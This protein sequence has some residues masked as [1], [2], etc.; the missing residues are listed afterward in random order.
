MAPSAQAGGGS[1]QAPGAGIR[2]GI[3]AVLLGPPGAGKG[4][5]VR[6]RPAELGRGA[7]SSGPAPR[8]CAWLPR[9]GTGRA[10][11]CRGPRRVSWSRAFRPVPLPKVGTRSG[12]RDSGSG[13]ARPGGSKS[14]RPRPLL[15]RIRPGR[16]AA[17]PPLK[18]PRWALTFR[19]SFPAGSEAGRDVLCLPPGHGGHAA[20][21]GGLGLRAGQATQRDDGFG[22]AGG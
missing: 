22:E 16:C 21:H 10:G 9:G 1:G 14:E 20:G 8:A 12:Q 6:G 18:S 13:G 2:R 11:L 3:R 17:G 5:Q 7:A 15:A 19:P 4:T